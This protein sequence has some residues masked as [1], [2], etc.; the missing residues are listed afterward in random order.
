[1]TSKKEAKGKGEVKEKAVKAAV[2]TGKRKKAI[3][4]ARFKKGKGVVKVNKTPLDKMQNEMMGLRIKEPLLLAGDA[5]RQFDIDVCVRGG[6][7]MG[8]ADASRQAIAKGLAN[9]LG[10]KVREIFLNYD[11]NLLV[12]DPRRTEPRKPPHSNW[13]ARR[14]KQRSKR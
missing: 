5:W 7:L 1:M 14:Y 6:G 13:G 11:R 8:Q 2:F 4:R 10:A 9:M 3:A 12:Y